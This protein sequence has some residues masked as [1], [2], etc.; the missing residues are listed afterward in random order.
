MN[1]MGSN[2][3]KTL[4]LYAN[5]CNL[6]MNETDEAKRALLKAEY[7]FNSIKASKHYSDIKEFKLNDNLSPCIVVASGD[8]K[9]MG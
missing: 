4:T 1:D 8:S 5:Y 6:V 9:S 7:I 3:L 2:K